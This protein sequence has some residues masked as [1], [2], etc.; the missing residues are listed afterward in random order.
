MPKTA[1]APKAQTNPQ[2]LP[3]LNLDLRPFVLFGLYAVLLYPAYLRG[4]FFAP[5]LMPTHMLTAVLFALAWYDKVLEREVSFL[6]DGLDYTSLALVGAYA[7]STLVAVDKRAAVGEIFKYTN[8]YMVYWM[9]SRVVRTQR[10]QERMLIVIVAGAVG[11]ALVAIAAS[12]GAIYFP[13]AFSGMRMNGTLQYPNSMAAYMLAAYVIAIALWVREQN[14]FR[15]LIYA[16]GSYSL[17]VV[18]LGT[19]SRGTWILMPPIYLLLLLGLPSRYLW[20]ATYTGIIS[21]TAAL[22]VARDLIPKALSGAGGST[23]TTML[24]GLAV[25]VLAELIHYAASEMMSRRVMSPVIRRALSILGILYVLGIGAVYLIYASRVLPSALSDLVPHTIQARVANIDPGQGSFLSRLVYDTD[26]FK[27]IKDYPILGTGGG[28]WNALYHQY[29]G[30]LYWTT[31]VHNHFLQ[32]WVETG[33]IGFAAL[34]SMWFFFFKNLVRRWRNRENDS[35]WAGDWGTALAA[36]TLGLHAV[37]DFDLSIPALSILLW[38]LFGII[39]G[40]AS[41]PS[42]T[43][44]TDI[45]SPSARVLW[46][47]TILATVAALLLFIPAFRIDQAGRVGAEGATALT[48]QEFLRAEKL[49]YRAHRLDPLTASYAVDLA[50]AY[51]ALGLEE[52]D[53]WR[54]ESAERFAKRARWSQPND[55]KVRLALINMYVLQGNLDR[56][57]PEAEKLM[58]LV[59]LAPLPYEH[60]ARV[61]TQAAAWALERDDLE[62]ARQYLEKV[63]QIPGQLNDANSRRNRLAEKL[64]PPLSL[65]PSMKL[66][67]GQAAYMKGDYAG[68]ADYLIQAGKAKEHGAAAKIWLAAA[69]AKSGQAETSEKAF[70]EALKM[71]GAL[72]AEYGRILDLKD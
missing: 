35:A 68:A 15:R 55:V 31:E 27:M 44:G 17:V 2:S 13:G 41:P 3:I 71:N 28:G 34:V 14:L 48:E 70:Q 63:E 21:L 18:L 30:I 61:F 51:T 37:F 11:A 69:Y 53:P 43:P 45:T 66:A 67:L 6:R 60:A 54:F 4:A 33:V 26:A 62:Q 49:L 38:A 22:V 7:L 56:A 59:P 16:S 72:E 9:V 32:V 40:R 57:V 50:Q 39:R 36:F 46:V 25:A 20:R 8:Y 42:K 52:E 23:K 12:A 10:D 58:E 47:R 64:E 19:M 29:Q 24:V 5:E 1:F 65:T